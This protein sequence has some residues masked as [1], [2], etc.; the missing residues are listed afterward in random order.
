MNVFTPQSPQLATKNTEPHALDEAFAELHEIGKRL[1]ASAKSTPS[2]NFATESAELIEHIGHQ[3]ESLKAQRTRL[4]E[5]LQQIDV[6]ESGA[7]RVD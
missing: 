2:R 6:T 3:L 5:L 1:D 7:S 4:A